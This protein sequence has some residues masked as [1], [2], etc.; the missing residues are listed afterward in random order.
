MFL[1]SRIYC[2]YDFTP[3]NLI[4]LYVSIYVVNSTGKSLSTCDGLEIRRS[5]VTSVSYLVGTCDRS[6][7]LWC[8]VS[9]PIFARDALKYQRSPSQF[10]S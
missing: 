7:D 5:L 10:S 3:V 1:V 2:L 4:A 9:A 8:R 6:V